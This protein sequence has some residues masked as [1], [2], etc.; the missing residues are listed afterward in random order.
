MNADY[1]LFRNA[2]ISTY[3]FLVV[4]PRSGGNA[5]SILLETGFNYYQFHIRDSTEAEN[6]KSRRRGS[7][8]AENVTQVPPPP[9][10][11]TLVKVFIS[12]IR[13]GPSGNKDVFHIIRSVSLLKERTKSVAPDVDWRVR[14]MVAGGDGTAMWTFSE[15]QRHRVD[16]NNVLVGVIPFG[17]GNDFA[18]ATGSHLKVGIPNEDPKTMVKRLV[19]H[20][21][22]FVAADFDLWN[23]Q[24]SVHEGG[25]F[26]KVDGTTRK[27]TPIMEM[28]PTGDFRKVSSLEFAMAN[29]CS[30]GV[31]SRI[32]VGFDRNRKDNALMNKAAYVF[33]GVKKILFHRRRLIDNIVESLSVRRFEPHGPAR[34]IFNTV[35]RESR[36]S[37]AHSLLSVHQRSS[38]DVDPS[39]LKQSRTFA[40]NLRTESAEASEA[41]PTLKPCVSICILNIP[42]FAGGADVWKSSA[43]RLGLELPQEQVNAQM[44]RKVQACLPGSVEQDFGDGRLEVVTFQSI[45]EIGASNIRKGLEKIFPTSMI[46]TG[47]RIYRGGGQFELKFREDLDPKQRIYFQVDGEYYVG[48]KMK[49]IVVSPD[50]RIK[51][52]VRP[53]KKPDQGHGRSSVCESL[54]DEIPT[55]SVVTEESVIVSEDCFGPELKQRPSVLLRNVKLQPQAPDFERVGCKAEAKSKDVVDTTPPD[56]A[57]E[58][59]YAGVLPEMDSA[60]LCYDVGPE[61]TS[62]KLGQGT[63]QDLRAQSM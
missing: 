50:T 30:V 16:P 27:K 54:S 49:G 34:L 18:N 43:N 40:G 14:V 44:W 21:V 3:F 32:G 37:R 36:L 13:K 28:S 59:D 24:A 26:A 52:L 56:L 63:R 10:N 55:E 9:M 5:A 60:K 6:K 45:I 61:S 47:W 4:N 42:S 39:H 15:L 48:Y 35:A 57:I 58:E 33:E 51:I 7:R 2:E 8:S 20:W 29:Y 38:S 12:D 23:V 11:D 53:D 46:P 17:T 31:E 41:A 19:A 25:S 1:E 22:T 62:P